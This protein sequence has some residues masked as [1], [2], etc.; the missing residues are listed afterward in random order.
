[1]MMALT[2]QTKKVYE[3]EKGEQLDLNG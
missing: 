1:M 2:H 3:P